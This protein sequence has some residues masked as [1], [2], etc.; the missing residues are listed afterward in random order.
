MKLTPAG[1]KRL[2]YFWLVVAIAIVG[3][4]AGVSTGV[5]GWII[6]IFLPYFYYLGLRGVLHKKLEDAVL[7]HFG[8]KRIGQEFKPTK[9]SFIKIPT[10]LDYLMDD[11]QVSNRSKVNV[12]RAHEGQIDKEPIKIISF[13]S[14]IGSG[15]QK[16]SRHYA[17][18]EFMT[19]KE[20]FAVQVCD[21]KNQFKRLFAGKVKLESK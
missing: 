10:N 8:F 3:F 4:V 11:Y 1:K 7:E 21:Q 2:F 20:H 13:G 12:L 17:G 16:Q 6:L 9:I 14:S 19:M 15:K 5:W 18:L